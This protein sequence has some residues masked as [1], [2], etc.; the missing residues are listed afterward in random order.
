MVSEETMER[1]KWNRRAEVV[2]SL[3]NRRTVET[4]MIL[5]FMWIS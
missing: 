4:F 1:V 5:K 2:V 3:V